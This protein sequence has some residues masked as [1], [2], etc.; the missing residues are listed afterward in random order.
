MYLRIGADLLMPAPDPHK[1]P[2]LV[3]YLVH[4]NRDSDKRLVLRENDRH[5]TA[6]VT[7][8]L[9]NSY[10]GPVPPKRMVQ[11]RLHLKTDSIAFRGHIDV[12]GAASGNVAFYLLEPFWRDHDI[13]FSTSVET[14]L[15]VFQ[16]A[17]VKIESTNGAVSL[18]W[19]IV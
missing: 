2:G 10:A 17:L 18:F 3:E 8:T 19:P 7:P 4:G 13:H 16:N 5:I 11:Y 6:W 9:I 1:P 12:T 14:S 15:N